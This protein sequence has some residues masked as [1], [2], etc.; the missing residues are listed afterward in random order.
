MNAPHKTSVV[1]ILGA[2]GIV[3]GDIGTSPLYALREC[4][5]AAHGIALNINNILGLLS[6]I[7]WSLTLIISIK[8]ISFIMRVDNNGE[9]GILALTAL[10]LRRATSKKQRKLLMLIGMMGAALFYGDGMITPAISVLSAVEGL[11]IVNPV[12]TIYTI[13]IT[14]SI[15]LI[16][17][18][19]QQH[20]TA[21]VGA[22]FGPIMLTWFLTLATTGI[23]AIV[24][25]PVVLTA[26]NPIYAVYFFVEN[27]WLAFMAVGSVF[28]V[29]TG[30]EALYADMG[31]FGTRPIR[32]AWFFIVFPALILNYFGQGSLLIT[33]PD[34]I[35]NPFFLLVP[36]YF[37]IPMVILATLATVIASQAVISGVFS[38][39]R[40]A[41]QLDYCPRL[42][43]DHTSEE[44]VGQIYVPWINWMLLAMIVALVLI[45]RSSSNLAAAYGIAVTGTMVI[46]SYLAFVAL[47]AFWGWGI[48]LGGAVAAV[49]LTL[50]LGF[51]A[52]N[53]LK[54]FQGG[55]LPL[56]I[57][58]GIFVLMY[59]WKRGRENLAVRMRH[60]SF[61]LDLF[62]ASLTHTTADS[63]VRVHGTAIFMT[64]NTEE[65]PTALL[66][67]LKH[68]KVLH[69]RIVFMTVL[70][71]DIPYVKPNKRLHVETLG[72]EIYRIVAHYGFR[73][74]PDVPEILK[75]AQPF[76]LEF[77]MMETTFFLSRETLTL[78]SK[79]ARHQS[80]WKDILF[81][82]MLRNA[83]SATDF[84][85]IPGNR[86]I[87]LG[88]QIDL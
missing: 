2:L 84:F 37:T 50:D 15:L 26:I 88:R 23:Y 47:Y 17:F 29:V 18:M 32:I 73:E 42:T 83:R 87:E 10:A 61:P 28:L 72:T 33:N 45:F 31:H 58:I 36:Q 77:N 48:W 40:Q 30:G 27:R 59:S 67:N 7:F 21:T 25:H 79:R 3:Y 9:G 70:T 39:T 1:S 5:H 4:F 80:L 62:L 85:R 20:G 86:V 81:I 56:L 60:E 35:E 57:G 13:P 46:T 11:E 44:T 76:N 49:F 38:L 12:F 71:Q 55:W 74:T 8:Y 14:L 69:D 63:P 64:S 68:N 24:Q 65:T 54:L 66:H 41:V 53:L 34:A 6:L 51:L 22:L 16:L 75:L 19:M 82:N 52:A 43:I 78:R